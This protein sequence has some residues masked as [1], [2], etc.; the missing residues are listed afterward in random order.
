MDIKRKTIGVARGIETTEREDGR[1]RG[2]ETVTPSPH[3]T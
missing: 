2:A 1:A 3:E